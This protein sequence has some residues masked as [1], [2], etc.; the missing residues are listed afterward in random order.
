MLGRSFLPVGPGLLDLYSQLGRP[1]FFFDE[2]QNLVRVYKDFQ[3]LHITNLP[4]YSQVLWSLELASE[5]FH[6]FFA[7]DFGGEESRPSDLQAW[8]A[9]GGILEERGPDWGKIQHHERVIPSLVTRKEFGRAHRKL[10]YKHSLLILAW[11]SRI[12]PSLQRRNSRKITVARD[13]RMGK[14][15]VSQK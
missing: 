14:I 5:F 11:K 1:N 10:G 12:Q 15:L 2:N 9:E 4:K 8:I 13:A 7:D 3:R 6:H